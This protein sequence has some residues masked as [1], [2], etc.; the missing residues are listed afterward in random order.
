MNNKEYYE[1]FKNNN[2]INIKEFENAMYT[3]IESIHFKP[4]AF[5]KSKWDEDTVKARGLFVNKS[6]KSIVARGYDKFFNVNQVEE[7]KLSNL[8]EL[9]Y[10]LIAYEKTDGYIGLLSYDKEYDILF[11]SSKTQPDNEYSKVFRDILFG[12]YITSQ[13]KH[14]EIKEY[15]KE[16]NVTIVFEVIAPDDFE[17]IIKYG[18]KKL[19][20]LDIVKNDYE[21]SKLDDHER[22]N[23]T[24][25]YG[26]DIKYPSYVLSNIKQLTN[27][28]TSMKDP[29]NKRF[30][31]K[32]G[33]VVESLN[34][35][36][37]KMKTGYY[38]RKMFGE[39]IFENRKHIYFT[40]KWI[41]V[42][43]VIVWN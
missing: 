42:K 35:F 33:Y 36:M 14:N 10:P 21:F 23:I 40:D 41:E 34:G 12:K 37:F 31:N 25:R 20:L 8:K 13:I 30:F 28:W 16:K 26:F 15:L 5:Y 6:D 18:D 17:Y 9:K 3:H 22:Y 29:D 7:T 38:M 11:T 1:N 39:E 19:V 2:L 27:L 43:G 24:Q 32:E 4:K